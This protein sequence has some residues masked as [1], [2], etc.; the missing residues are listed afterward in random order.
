MN[1][2]HQM[3]VV[4]SCRYDGIDY[5]KVDMP[6]LITCLY[7]TSTSGYV[8]VGVP[9]NNEHKKIMYKKNLDYM[10]KIF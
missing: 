9:S 3:I 7:Q 2:S 6:N 5:L 10:I 4:K 1:A 8:C